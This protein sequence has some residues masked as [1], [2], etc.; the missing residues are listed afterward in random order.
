MTRAAGTEPRTTDDSPPADGAPGTAAPEVKDASH[1]VNGG[2]KRR[3]LRYRVIANP[4]AGIAGRLPITPANI[5]ELRA[6]LE[7]HGL[8]ADVVEPH[9]ED[10]ARAAVRQAIED[11]VDVIVAAGGDGTVHLVADALVGTDR[12]LG[13][14]PMGRVMNIARSLGIGRDLDRAAQILAEGNV[15]VIDVG[16]AAAADGHTVYFLEA[17]SVG[18]NAAIFR[19]V[20]R[21]D[22]GDPRSVLRTIWVALRYRPARTTVR[23]DDRVVRRRALMVTASVGPYTGLAMTVAPN[24]RLDDGRFDVVVFRGYSKLELLTHLASIAFG[25]RRYT[26]KSVTYRSATVRITSRHPQPARAD[27]YDLGHTPVT[28]RTRAQALRVVA[29]A[30]GEGSP[31]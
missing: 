15:R 13:I 20:T 23:L 7:K 26:P 5:D 30:G 1:P 27:N 4:S 31:A 17:G 19:E 14:L 18:L 22:E 28:Y 8:G 16:E 3:P 6:V 29:P 25:R 10:S 12:I 11:K 21:A 9:D 2:P 24:A